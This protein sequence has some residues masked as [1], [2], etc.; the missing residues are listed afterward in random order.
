MNKMWET[1]SGNHLLCRSF[2]PEGAFDVAKREWD[3]G[4]YEVK[5]DMVEYDLNNNEISRTTVSN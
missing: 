3:C 2:C 1:I 5:V 4:H